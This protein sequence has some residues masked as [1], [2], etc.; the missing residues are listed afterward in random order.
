MEGCVRPTSFVNSI[1]TMPP[2]SVGLPSSKGKSHFSL[3][4]V[5]R[6]A[7]TP[8]SHRPGLSQT[9]EA[10]RFF[11]FCI[12]IPWGQWLAARSSQKWQKKLEGTPKSE[13]QSS[14]SDTLE[15]D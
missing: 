2:F 12:T 9:A 3:P 14:A 7:Q 6:T 11:L 4:M 10:L 8:R 15:L 13:A 5:L 1:V